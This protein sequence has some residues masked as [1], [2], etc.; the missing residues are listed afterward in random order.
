[1]KEKTF[2]EHLE[3]LRRRIISYLIVLLLTSVLAFSFSEEFLRYVLKLVGK[4]IFLSPAEGFFVHLKTAL[5]L[6]FLISLPMLFYEVWAF[7]SS[8]LKEKEI[9]FLKIFCFSSLILFLCGILF[10]YFVIL[11]LAIN[12]LLSYQSPVML[13]MLS[14]NQY[15]SFLYALL[16]SFGF[17]FELPLLIVF[18][19]QLNIIGPGF[20]KQKR[21]F[22]FL[23]IFIVAAILTPPDVITQI[24][25]AL[26]LLILYESG[27]IL[28]RVVARRRKAK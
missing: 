18:L 1:M 15:L 23:L 17:I 2:I 24:L 22:A 10:A 26:P 13:A 19:T 4:T 16:I 21:K 14:V 9:F 3:E 8:A 11:P 7:V 6:G 12:F 28:S 20:L 27:I 5:F 25:M